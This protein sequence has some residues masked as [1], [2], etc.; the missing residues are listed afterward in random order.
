MALSAWPAWLLT[1]TLHV[2]PT[3]LEQV[4]ELEAAVADTAAQEMD[5]RDALRVCV[6]KRSHHMAVVRLSF[7]T[8]TRP[9]L[10]Q[11]CGRRITAP[12]H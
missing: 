11:W 2:P 3:P 9:R 8:F 4:V 5:L 12:G 7:A 10:G 1:N 6:V